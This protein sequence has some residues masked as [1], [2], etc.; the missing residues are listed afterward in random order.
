MYIN[1]NDSNEKF[2]HDLS[3]FLDSDKDHDICQLAS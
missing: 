3:K 2:S 1:F